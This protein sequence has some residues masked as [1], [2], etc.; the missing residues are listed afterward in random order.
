MQSLLVKPA[1]TL[2]QPI[3]P[4]QSP[5]VG[6]QPVADAHVG[7]QAP[8]ASQVVQG[9]HVALQHLPRLQTFDAHCV[10]IVHVWPK[11][12]LQVPLGSHSLLAGHACAPLV[13]QT[14]LSCVG[15]GVVR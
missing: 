15:A 8:V 10:F 4:E 9:P 11:L 13:K 12:S 7:T 3:V 14:S 5:I 2:E 6:T 1:N